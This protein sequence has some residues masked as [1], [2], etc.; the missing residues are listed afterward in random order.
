MAKQV[1]AGKRH[2]GDDINLEALQRE[3]HEMEHKVIQARSRLEDVKANLKVRDDIF[4]DGKYYEQSLLDSLREAH[5]E[6][7]ELEDQK[8]L[9]ETQIATN[10]EIK[11]RIDSVRKE[12]DMLQEK[13]SQ[14]TRQPFFNRE[15][16]AGNLA[17][18]D[19]LSAKLEEATNK[20]ND[21]T[22]MIH[23]H[24]KEI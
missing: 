16:D 23:K 21:D 20:F 6:R 5:R 1:E 2:S 10:A 17:Q 9:M 11:D 8:R 12:R 7:S 4:K 24:Q 3:K 13:L 22:A 19:Q 18:L 14:V 15:K